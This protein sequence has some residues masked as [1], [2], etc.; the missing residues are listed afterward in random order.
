M[1]IQ[2]SKKDIK[3]KAKA[4]EAK[5]EVK[6]EVKFNDAGEKFIDPEQFDKPRSVGE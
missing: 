3:E 6:A 2:K 5:A 4:K 1:A